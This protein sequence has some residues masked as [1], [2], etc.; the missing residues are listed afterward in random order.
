MGI[1][2]ADRLLAGSLGE[3]G[4]ELSDLPFGRIRRIFYKGSPDDDDC[5]AGGRA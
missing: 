4:I 3:L 5:E 1:G 2:D